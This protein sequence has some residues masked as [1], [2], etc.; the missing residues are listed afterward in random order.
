MIPAEFDYIAPTSLDEALRLHQLINGC[1]AALEAVE[2]AA[3]E[4]ADRISRSQ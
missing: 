4:R 1:L 2:S 3:L